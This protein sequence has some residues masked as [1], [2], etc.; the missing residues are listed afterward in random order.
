[1]KPF[2]KWA[3]G[4]RWL[5]RRLKDLAEL[6]FERLIEPFAGSAAV[7]F[8]VEPESAILNDSNSR[9]I[10]TYRVLSSRPEDLYSLLCSH[11]KLHSRDYYYQM[12]G[13]TFDN[14]L[15]RAAQFI[16]L[17]RTCWNGLYRENRL[18]VFNVPKGTKETVVFPD[19][20][21]EHAAQI[22]K[23]SEIRSADFEQVINEAEHRDLVFV[24]PPYTVKHNRNGFLKY[25]EKIFSWEDQMRLAT[26]LRRLSD[27]GAMVI[28]TN[29][30]HNSVIDMY[31]GWSDIFALERASVLSGDPRFRASTQEALILINVFVGDV[32]ASTACDDQSPST[33]R[34][35]AQA[36]PA[37][38]P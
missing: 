38:S 5:T 14:D 2:L 3:G 20:N 10:E 15:Q 12:R 33:A 8:H 16:Y 29:A 6:G 19:D 30:Y 22:L 34:P 27:R 23:R 21:F 4:K 9:L 13:F 28:M 11:Q 37:P 32:I 36:P 26:S 25:N 31:A 1:V 24:D 7:F 35:P 17:N 18:G